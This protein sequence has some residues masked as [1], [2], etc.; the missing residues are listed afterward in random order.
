MSIA[1]NIKFSIIWRTD[2]DLDYILWILCESNFKS[3]WNEDDS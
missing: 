3:E 1:F 2:N